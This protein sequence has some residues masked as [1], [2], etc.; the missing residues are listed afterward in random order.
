MLSLYAKNL[1]GDVL[2]FTAPSK[3]AIRL[4]L[5]MKVCSGDV[6]RL[7]LLQ[8]DDS[9]QS[10]DMKDG[11]TVLYLIKDKETLQVH[12]HLSDHDKYDFT[13]KKLYYPGEIMIFSSDWRYNG[14]EQREKR[15]KLIYSYKFHYN[16]EEN[17][18]IP[19]THSTLDY[20]EGGYE[21]HISHFAEKWKSIYD[22][23][24]SD[25]DILDEYRHLIYRSIYRK[26]Y[27]AIYLAS[28]HPSNKYRNRTRR[29]HFEVATEHRQLRQRAYEFRK[30]PPPY[31][32]KQ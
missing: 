2:S 30:I 16:K 9:D 26:W 17:I 13:T 14:K 31:P 6:S 18:F 15:D 12:F 4:E 25:P 28:T 24:L 11:D 1:S 10:S 23:I 5:A 19:Q 22:I 3:D 27:R 7:V 21:L 29:I 8:D 20:E 32:R